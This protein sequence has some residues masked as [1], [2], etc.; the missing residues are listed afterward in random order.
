M[1]NPPHFGGGYGGVHA[2]GR[3]RFPLRCREGHPVILR[4]FR[5]RWTP[6]RRPEIAD[7]HPVASAT[8]FCHEYG[9]AW[10][11]RGPLGV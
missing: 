7:S 1:A 5:A 2:H 6:T 11:S 3:I 8:A 10:A 9:V 4:V